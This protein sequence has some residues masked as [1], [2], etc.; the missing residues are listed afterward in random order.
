MQTIFTNHKKFGD[1]F[2]TEFS[3][4]VKHADSLL[5]ASGYFGTS[6]IEDFK[7]SMIKIARRK[8]CKILLGM[9]FY[10]GVTI[11][12]KDA[13]ESL[14]AKLRKISPNSG[15]YI[16][17]KPYHGKI[18][19]F[20]I[21]GSDSLYLGSSNFSKEGFA[22]RLEC[23]SLIKDI[24]TSQDVSNFLN[25]LFNADTTSE[26]SKVDLPIKRRKKESIVASKLLEDYEI[27]SSDFPDVKSAMGIC[28]ILLRVDDQPA[29]SLNLF[30]DKGRVNKSGK[31]AP[32]PWYE[33]E[34]TARR[35]EIKNPFYPKSILNKEGKKSRSGSFYAYIK[36]EDS[37]FKI[38]MG[39]YS[40]NGKAI[41]SHADSG[42]RETLGHFIKG[43]L[44]RVGVLAKGER[45]TSDTLD[46]YG[47]NYINLIKISDKEYI[48]DF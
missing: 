8:E 43:K 12:Q 44:E 5:I 45:I 34:I 32:R 27:S 46:A 18:Y 3:N 2:F 41:S 9:I 23:T 4:K 25:F 6:A 38:K 33:V 37:Y 17:R 29:S 1:T 10:E 30:F 48:L 7:N 22:S 42:G 39:V 14:D 47:R 20:S 40:D 31:Y 35:S 36:D 21:E 19:K 24:S 13:L 28:K 11:K 15:V 26:L 16:S